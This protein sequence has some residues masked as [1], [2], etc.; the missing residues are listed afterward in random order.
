RSRIPGRLVAR[1]LSKVRAQTDRRH[2]YLSNRRRLVRG[3]Q[4]GRL[5]R[6]D[7]MN[8][9]GKTEAQYEDRSQ[10]PACRYR[11]HHH[12]RIQLTQAAQ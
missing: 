8:T 6:P 4:S 10:I 12:A 2:R 11:S 7:L 9:A 3:R 5:L 1:N